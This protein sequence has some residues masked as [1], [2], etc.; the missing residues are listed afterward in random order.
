MEIPR[1]INEYHPTKCSPNA[2]GVS[3]TAIRRTTGD[4][5]Q[6]AQFVSINSSKLK[7]FAQVLV[8]KISENE[9]SRQNNVQDKDIEGD[10][11]NNS[12]SYIEWDECGWHFCDDRVDK[13]GNGVLTTQYIFV[14]DALNWCFWPTKDFEYEQL[15]MSLTNVLRKDNHAFDAMRLLNLKLEE[16]QSWFLPN[17]LP[18]PAERLNKIHELGYVLHTQFDGQA[19]NLVKRANNSATKLVDL[20]VQYFPGFRDHSIYNGKQVFFYKRAQILVGDLWAA[21]GRQTNFTNSSDDLGTSASETSNHCNFPDISEL[22]MFADYRVPQLLREEGLLVY[23]EELAKKVDEYV[24]IPSNSKEEVEIRSCTVQCVEMLL[25]AI[26]DHFLQDKDRYHS[27]L[28][29]RVCK[30]T[31]VELDWLLWQI[32]EG[33]CKIMKPHHRTLTVYY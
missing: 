13:G 10:C 15:A 24:E 21:F 12:V 25:N 1:S 8:M 20:V 7:D 18:T 3:C 28:K 14:L 22:T 27:D 6:D 2:G 26:K 33:R 4:V 29:E 23:A 31:S 11:N 32:G 5:L 19:I 17:I 30:I 16:L 9:K